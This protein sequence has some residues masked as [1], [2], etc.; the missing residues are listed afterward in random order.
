MIKWYRYMG[1]NESDERRIVHI[2]L[3]CDAELGHSSR[4][5]VFLSFGVRDVVPVEAGAIPH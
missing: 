3:Q 4:L 1:E 2:S 5:R